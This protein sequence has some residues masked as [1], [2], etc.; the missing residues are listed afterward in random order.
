MANLKITLVGGG[1]YS[2]TPGMLRNLLGSKRLNGSHVVLHDLNPEPLALTY[3]LALKCKELTGTAITFQQTTDRG[4]AL[5]GADYVVV[6]I[7]TGRLQTMRVDLGVPEKYGIFQTVGDTVGPGGLSRALRNVPVFLG[8]AREME[9]RCPGAWMLNI[10]NPLSALTRAVTKETSI[11]ALGICHGVLN[12]A[13]DYAR[14]LG[15]EL[16]DCAYVNT[17]IDHCSW[18]SEFVVKGRCAQELL[19]ERGVDKWLGLPPAQAKEDKVFGP[20]YEFRCGVMLGRMLGALPGVG[21]RHTTE[22][23]P[24]FLQGLDNVKRYGLVRTTIA[25]RE[26]HYA[27]A[28]ARIERWLSGEEKLELPEATDVVGARQSDDVAAWICALAGGPAIEDNV[29]ASNIGQIPEL[30]AGAVVETRGVLDGTGCRPLASPLPRQLVPIVLP[31]VVREELTVEA[32]VEG[33]FDKAL[34]VLATDPLVGGVET[35]RP[36]LEEMLS[37]NKEWLPQFEL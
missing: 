8:M 17:G 31:H 33:S 18:F 3:Q 12:T 21:D 35:A 9:K 15:A 25:D 32:A 11:R 2:W 28:R 26:R 10:S 5:D 6:T 13:R 36:M 24:T 22:F 20:L 4:A 14:F 23:L 34:A 19:T 27:R 30:P 29:N 37:A 16:T 1:S 7:S